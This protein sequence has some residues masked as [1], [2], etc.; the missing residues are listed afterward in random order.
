MKTID[1]S[2]S[3]KN[4]RGKSV[5]KVIFVNIGRSDDIGRAKTCGP[6]EEID[7][8]ME[9]GAPGIVGNRRGPPSGAAL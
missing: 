8:G 6:M 7:L 2:R 1:L 9:T 5:S 3:S 4:W